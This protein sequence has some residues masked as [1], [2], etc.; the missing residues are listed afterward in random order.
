MADLKHLRA[1]KRITVTE[2]EAIGYMAVTFMAGI[3]FTFGLL[4]LLSMGK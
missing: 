2:R 4:L 3:G 1:E